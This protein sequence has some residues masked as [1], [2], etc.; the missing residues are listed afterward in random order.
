MLR[1]PDGVAACWVAC[2]VEGLAKTLM[3]AMSV[4]GKLVADQM[5]HTLDANQNVYTQSPVA[6]RQEGVNRLEIAVSG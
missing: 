2:V 6:L 4:E 1:N 5:G 3:N